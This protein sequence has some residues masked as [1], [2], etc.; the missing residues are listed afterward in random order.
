MTPLPHDLEPPLRLLVPASTSNL[1]PGFDFLGLSLSLYLSV[2]VLRREAGERHRY[3]NVE[4]HARS[5]PGT[6]EDLLLR[7][8]DRTGPHRTPFLFEVD[9]DIPVGRG[10]GSSGAAVA[11]GLLLGAALSGEEFSL[12]RLLG[13]G[14]EIEGHPDNVTASLFGGCTLCHPHAGL[15]G[16]AVMIPNHLDPSIGFAVAWPASPL[17]TERARAALPDRV[18]FADAVENPRRLALLLE[19]LRRG[20][21]ELIALG[22]EDRLHTAARLP[23]IPGAAEAI[24][25]ARDAG[26]WLAA[27][28]GAGSGLVALGPRSRS[29]A[30]A[31]AM[32]DAFEE[33]GAGGSARVVEP[34]L[35]TPEV[36]AI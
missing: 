32:Q 21:P 27:I 19:G 5:W 6:T 22:G 36:T 35:G 8:F 15:D 34:V 12:R 11:A 24:G 33:Q 4:G 14:I 2:R 3:G 1:G 17:A 26:A 23:L 20:D 10:F 31:R 25:A 13:I 16:A 18:A 9:S 29:E 28:S 30:V 7:A